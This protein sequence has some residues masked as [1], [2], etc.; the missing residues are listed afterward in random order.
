MGLLPASVGGGTMP[1]TNMNHP[2]HP[3]LR[4]RVQFIEQQHGIK[5]D[6]RQGYPAPARDRAFR[7]VMEV[8]H[9]NQWC[10]QPREVHL[11]DK[12]HNLRRPLQDWTVGERVS[13]SHPEGLDTLAV[14]D[15]GLVYL[16]VDL[17]GIF[18][19]SD[20]V[21]ANL[22][23]DS[24]F[25]VAAPMAA[26]HVK[27]YDWSRERQA[28]VGWRVEAID[29]QVRRWRQNVRDND[30][31][32]DGLTQRIATLVRFNGELR[33]NISASV[34]GTRSRQ[35]EKAQEEFL[36]LTRMMPGVVKDV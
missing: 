30:L 28:F 36:A 8:V 26:E 33:Q 27:N 20:G 35:T 9:A 22:L 19:Y 31:E 14:V 13:V 29:A 12:V 21:D 24:I 16:L 7:P 3:G 4:A 1:N 17:E 6:W 2:H 25:D 18:E 32:L 5:I 11:G 15:G 23:F 10:D 34:G